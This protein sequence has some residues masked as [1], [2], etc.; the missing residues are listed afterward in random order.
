MSIYSRKPN[1]YYITRPDVPI[2]QRKAKEEL[3]DKNKDLDEDSDSGYG[4]SLLCFANEKVLLVFNGVIE[5][6]ANRYNVANSSCFFL[7]TMLTGPFRESSQSRIDIYLHDHITFEVFEAIVKY[8]ETRKFNQDHSKLDYYLTMIQLAYVWLYDELVSIVETHIIGLIDIETIAA[9][10]TLGNILN[11][12]KLNKECMKLEQDLDYGMG[13]L[14]RGW[15]RCHLPGHQTHHYANCVS[16]IE[17]LTGWEEEETQQTDKRP[18]DVKV[19]STLEEA[20]ESSH[21]LSEDE[22]NLRDTEN[23]FNRV[24]GKLGRRGV[25]RR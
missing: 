2:L 14:Q 6:E 22:A 3:E 7:R 1:G 15:S 24:H 12:P 13:T 10:H 18:S 25:M 11:L 17:M 19:S 21:Y 5:I 23:L 16:F 8:A 4:E 20:K 9:I